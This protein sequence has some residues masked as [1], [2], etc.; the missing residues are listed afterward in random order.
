MIKNVLLDMDN[1]IL[2]F[3]AAERSALIKTL[4]HMGLSPDDAML[5]R[6]SE[7]N[8]SQWKLLEKGELTIPEL[9]IRRYKLFFDEYGV[10]CSAEDAAKYYEGQ[11]GMGWFFMD[12]AKELL[13]ALYGK[14][15]LYI[16]SNGLTA[17]Q[18]RRIQHTGID[19]YM[20]GI[21]L[22]QEVG[23]VKPK[24]EFFDYC[25]A[26]IDGFVKEE[27]VIVGDSL[28]SDIKGGKNAGIKTIWF[29]AL[30]EKAPEELIPDYEFN[31]LSDLP[32][33]LQKI[34]GK[35]VNI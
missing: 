6:Y 31:K 14:Y 10:N 17:V 1:T 30:G 34:Q 8:L 4:E 11:L 22:S 33:L 9:K 12:G 26:R 32:E 5:Q 29:N 25:F 16:V 23:A 3:D 24:K 27:T 21:F 15:R 20:E 2:D 35:N 19:K 13:E 28:S 18:S 7:I